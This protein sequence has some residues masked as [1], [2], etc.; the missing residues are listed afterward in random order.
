MSEYIFSTAGEEVTANGDNSRVVHHYDGITEFNGIDMENSRFDHI[1]IRMGRS[2]LLLWREQ[3]DSFNEL[4]SDMVTNGFES[5]I[6]KRSV[7]SY[8]LDAY[9]GYLDTIADNAVDNFDEGLRG[10][11]GGL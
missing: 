6:N 9:Q 3:L 1:A 7:A 11:L 8:A 10:L 2:V 4:S 5:V